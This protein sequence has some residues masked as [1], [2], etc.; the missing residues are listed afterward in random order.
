MGDV[1]KAEELAGAIFEQKAGNA[2]KKARGRRCSYLLLIFGLQ[3][4]C[5]IVLTLGVLWVAIQLLRLTDFLGVSRE[6]PGLTYL[7]NYP[8]PPPPP[9]TVL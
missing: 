4:L 8:D 1:S 9:A 6:P 2:L 5:C 7:I 3:F